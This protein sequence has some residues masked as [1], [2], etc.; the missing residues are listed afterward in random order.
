MTERL[1]KKRERCFNYLIAL[2][3]LSL[4]LCDSTINNTCFSYTIPLIVPEFLFG[5]VITPVKVL[6]MSVAT[7]FSAFNIDWDGVSLY[8]SFYNNFSL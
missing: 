3:P 8:E 4:C 5:V 2:R 7:F 6:F 1:F